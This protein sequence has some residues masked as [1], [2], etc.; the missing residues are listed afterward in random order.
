MNISFHE[1]VFLAQLI[2]IHTQYRHAS[3]SHLKASADP[4]KLVSASL[5]SEHQKPSTAEFIM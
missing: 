3:S 5:A 2:F 4:I 1:V